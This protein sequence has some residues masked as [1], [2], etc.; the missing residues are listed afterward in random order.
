MRDSMPNPESCALK[1]LGRSAPALTP[2]CLE[3]EDGGWSDQEGEK[4]VLPVLE[5]LTNEI[6]LSDV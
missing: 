3:T 6:M 1:G 5:C 2:V 4:Q